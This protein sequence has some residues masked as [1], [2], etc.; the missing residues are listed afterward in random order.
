MIGNT[1]V[2]FVAR[3]LFGLACGILICATPK[4][5]DESIPPNVMDNGYGIST[6]LFINIAIFISFLFGLGT[7]KIPCPDQ[8]DTC[9]NNIDNADATREPAHYSGA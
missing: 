6:N 8:E 9:L 5:I 2:L 1:Y 7:D 4:I 3:F